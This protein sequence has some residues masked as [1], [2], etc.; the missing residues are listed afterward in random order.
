M[1]SKEGRK[2]EA[3]AGIVGIA[4][5]QVTRSGSVGTNPGGKE[6]KPIRRASKAQTRKEEKP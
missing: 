1:P 6:E 3:K 4:T 5:N 2:E